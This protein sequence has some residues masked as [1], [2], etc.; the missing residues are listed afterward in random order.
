LFVTNAT[1]SDPGVYRSV[2]N[3]TLTDLTVIGSIN[4]NLPLPSGSQAN[5]HGTL[6]AS[7]L[8]TAVPTCDGNHWLII[9]DWSDYAFANSRRLMVYLVTDSTVTYIGKSDDVVNQSYGQLKAPQTEPK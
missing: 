9:G 3:S 2:L 7:E 8:I 1:E 5:S 4:L 6:K